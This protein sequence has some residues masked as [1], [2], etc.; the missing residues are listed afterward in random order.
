MAKNYGIGKV[1]IGLVAGA[2][3]GL[4]GGMKLNRPSD[5]LPQ[6]ANPVYTQEQAP[7][8]LEGQPF[9]DA[10]QRAEAERLSHPSAVENRLASRGIANLNVGLDIVS[11]LYR[12]APEL[13]SQ[14][15]RLTGCL[16]D[17]KQFWRG[18][19]VYGLPSSAFGEGD[20]DI[21][22]CLKEWYGGKDR[23]QLWILDYNVDQAKK[24]PG[25]LG[26]GGLERLLKEQS[27]LRGKIFGHEEPLLTEDDLQKMLD[28]QMLEGS[29]ND[30]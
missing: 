24:N 26:P 16:S 19:G 3:I 10:V 30:K 13:T 29:Y 6:R 27:L 15:D 7:N 21:D 8:S 12:A 20:L 4:L 5:A 2:A 9:Y 14:L 18:V 1:A 28:E 11:Q 25:T 22:T 17:N 23:R